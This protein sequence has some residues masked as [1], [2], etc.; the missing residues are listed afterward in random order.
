V[1]PKINNSLLEGTSKKILGSNPHFSQVLDGFILESQF[2]L[3]N[4]ASVHGGLAWH[5]LQPVWYELGLMNRTQAEACATGKRQDY[6]IRAI[7]RLLL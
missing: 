1:P 7:A 2:D 5:R 6:S 3:S 4:C